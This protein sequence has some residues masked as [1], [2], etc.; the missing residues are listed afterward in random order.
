[1]ID[2]DPL[3]PPLPTSP[4]LTSIRSAISASAVQPPH[5]C[6]LLLFTQAIDSRSFFPAGLTAISG[7]ATNLTTPPTPNYMRHPVMMLAKIDRTTVII[8]QQSGVG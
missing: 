6:M 7:A 8:G 3:H 2:C 4:F 1:M 5:Y